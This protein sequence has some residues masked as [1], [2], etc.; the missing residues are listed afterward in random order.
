MTFHD[1]RIQN[2]TAYDNAIKRNILANAAITFDRTHP[3]ANEIREF[4]GSGKV[5]NEYGELA[6]YKDNF[7]GSLANSLDT[8]GK[9]TENQIAAVRKIISDRAVKK[10]EWACEKAALD[11][12]RAH[13]GIVGQKT[14]LTLTI[15]HIVVLDG[16]YGTSYIYILEDAD[17]NIVIYKGNAH[18]VVWT[19]EGTV[20]TKG[21]TLTVTATIKEH[22]VREGVKQTIIQRPKSI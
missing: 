4:L 5:W 16:V 9:L 2:P 14:T 21:D 20:R 3:D 17:K 18:S 15:G 13:I 10:A 6:G 1:T 7:V 12:K 8:Y 19:P 11:A 22:G